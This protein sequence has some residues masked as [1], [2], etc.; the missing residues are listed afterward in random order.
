MPKKDEK[1]RFLTMD[2]FNGLTRKE[3]AAYL[4]RAAAEIT[5]QQLGDDPPQS[6]FKNGPPPPPPTKKPVQRE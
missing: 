5:K 6:L 4:E 2:E 3:K 1:F